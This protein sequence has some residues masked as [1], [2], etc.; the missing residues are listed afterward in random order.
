MVRR[1]RRRSTRSDERRRAGSGGPLSRPAANTDQRRGDVGRQRGRRP[2][3]QPARPVAREPGPDLSGRMGGWRTQGAGLATPP[4]IG[5][6]VGEQRVERPLAVGPGGLKAGVAHELGDGDQ[7]DPARTSC[8]PKVWRSTWGPNGSRGSSPRP[9]NSPKRPTMVRTER[10]LRRPPRW[11]RTSA[12]R[13]SAPGQ[14]GRTWSQAWRTER[15]SAWTG[16]CAACRRRRPCP[17][18]RARPC[19]P[20]GGRHRRPGARP[21]CRAARRSRGAGRRPGREPTRPSP[22]RA[23]SGGPAAPRGRVGPWWPAGLRGGRRP[24]P[25]HA[26]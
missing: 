13:L 8:V 17:G 9:A 3:C 4:W 15:S 19:G 5:S 6:A 10:S 23:G 11:L 26:E 14:V 20:S 1:S 7:V 24:G 12:A 18:P 25:G 22:R 2:P 16:A 21:R